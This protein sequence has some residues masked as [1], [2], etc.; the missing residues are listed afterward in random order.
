MQIAPLH[1]AYSHPYLWAEE[2][3]LQD[4]SHFLTRFLN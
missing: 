2:F 4:E 1:A 3:F